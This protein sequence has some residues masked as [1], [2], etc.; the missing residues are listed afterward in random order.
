M[1]TNWKTLSFGEQLNSQLSFPIF[2]LASLSFTYVCVVQD[3]TE[4]WSEFIHRIRTSLFLWL[5]PFQYFSSPLTFQHTLSSCS[6]GQRTMDFFIWI[7]ATSHGADLILFTSWKLRKID[8]SPFAIALFQDLTPSRICLLLFNFLCLQVVVFCIF[9]KF[10][11]VI[12][13]GADKLVGTYLSIP[14]VKIAGVLLF[15]FIV[16]TFAVRCIKCWRWGWGR[17]EIL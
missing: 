1:D 17:G 3:L 14:K 11:V 7:L 9:S 6:L 13:G 16:F 2:S 12:C 15:V 8:N 10:I 5:I 4:A